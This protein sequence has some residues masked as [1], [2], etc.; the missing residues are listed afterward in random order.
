MFTSFSK[1]ESVSLHLSGPK[2]FPPISPILNS[3]STGPTINEHIT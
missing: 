1:T 2:N 3:L